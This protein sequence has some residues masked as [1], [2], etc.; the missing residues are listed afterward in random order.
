MLRCQVGDP[1]KLKGAFLSILAAFEFS[2]FLDAVS[3]SS[4]NGGV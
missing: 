4:R 2:D 3:E 1:L